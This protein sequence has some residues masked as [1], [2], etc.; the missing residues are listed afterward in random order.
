MMFFSCFARWGKKH[1]DEF[2]SKLLVNDY[3]M[4][5]PYGARKKIINGSGYR[6]FAPTGHRKDFE[7]ELD[8]WSMPR[9]GYLSIK[10]CTR[11]NFLAP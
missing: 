11:G 3:A 10:K 6:H 8:E 1:Y 5:C 2:R 7:Y 9:R 4:C